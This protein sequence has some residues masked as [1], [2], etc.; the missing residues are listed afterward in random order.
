[1][2]RY[3]FILAALAFAALASPAF[4]VNCFWV[5]G[6]GTWDGT[7]TGGGGAGGIKWASA[8]GGG[9][10]CTATSGPAAGVPGPSDTA[11]FDANSG[12]GTITGSPTGTGLTL[13][14]LTTGAFTGTLDFSV[15]NPSLTI[16]TWD[17]S[18]T[19]TRTI[20]CGTGTFSFNGTNPNVGMTWGTTTNLTLSCASATF[21][22]S[23]ATTNQR[24][25]TLGN[26][27][28]TYPTITVGANSSG[29][30]W[31]VSGS[32]ITAITAM[33]I[34]SPQTIQFGSGATFP[35]TTLTCSGGSTSALLS[36]SSNSTIT[37]TTISSANA[38]SCPW[39]TVRAIAFAGGGNATFANSFDLLRNSIS[40]GGTLL[41]T[42]PSGTAGGRIIGG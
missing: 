12:G 39:A 2:K 3:L 22:F 9:T 19:G 35:I 21:A 14:T 6:T 40:G 33:T 42:Q 29:G 10:A 20:N 13:T 4:A 24:L 36:I 5:G 8:T 16:S 11:T 18:G 26:T 23:G 31:I 25:I 30:V 32:N 7:N 28:L 38:I 17:N 34:T 41:I 1:M 37:Q 15:S 27:A